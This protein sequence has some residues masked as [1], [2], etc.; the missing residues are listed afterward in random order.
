MPAVKGVCHA[1][2]LP[3]QIADSFTEFLVRCGL[4]AGVEGLTDGAHVLH[5]RL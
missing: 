1:D 2:A 5:S 4:L 3:V